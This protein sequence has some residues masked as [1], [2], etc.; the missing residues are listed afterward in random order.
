MKNKIF[1][2][3]FSEEVF[4][5]TYS[6][7]N[8]SFD[9]MIQRVAKSL[10]SVEKDK[11]K[12]EEKFTGILKS[13]KF[14]PGGR[15]LSNAGTPL[16]GTT[17]I[18]CFVD[19]LQGEDQDSMNGI[20]AALKRQGLILCS[21]GGYGFCCDV[22]RPRGGFI[23]GIGNETPGSVV[24]LEMWDTQSKVITE[25]SGRKSQR[26]DSKKKIRKGAQM[27]TQSCWHP[28]IEEFITAKQTPGRLTKFNMS[29]LITDEFMN[30][31][32]NNKSWDLIFPDFE[33]DKP[34]YKKNW[35]GD[36]KKWVSLGGKI[37]VYKTFE[38]ANE[39]WDLI[40]SSTYNRNEPGVLFVDTINRLNNLYYCEYISSTNPCVSKD[41]VIQTPKGNFTIE[42]LLKNKDEV[43]EIYSYNVEKQ[44]VE[45]DK[46]KD[47][48][49]TKEKANIIELELDNG[50]KLKLTPD[51][52][53]YTKN[54]GWIQAGLL[55]QEDILLII[56]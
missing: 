46:I 10:A 26:K 47:V 7:N 44:K 3:D 41:I 15:I 52:K 11:E 39:L 1:N 53:V 13:L 2:N 45:I 4:N 54:R 9:S 35:N 5:L 34:F 18:N 42:E 37:R 12:W 49:L 21:E 48:F 14:I 50:E 32:K 51:H 24:M 27:V 55:T 22:I 23:S 38:N 29:V 40:M 17:F 25:G 43:K 20:F 31:V 33:A 36:I 56:D 19:G 16:K 30:A 28:D 6:Y 8:E